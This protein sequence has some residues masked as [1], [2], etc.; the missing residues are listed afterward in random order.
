MK[1]FILLSIAVILIFSLFGCTEEK[2][3]A[4]ESTEEEARV[5]MTM[6]IDGTEY[7]VKY[8]LYRALFL[9]N[10]SRVDGG[11]NS[12]WTSEKSDEYIEKINKIIT[13]RTSEIFSVIHLATEIGF[14][15]YSEEVN[16]KI[17]TYV[18]GAVEGDGNQSGHGSYEKYLESLKNNNL[19]YSVATLMAR[20]AL[21]EEAIDKY[22]LG[23]Y[24]STLEVQKDGEFAYTKK[25]VKNYY[26]SSEC[27]RVLQS[28]FS[29]GIK[30]VEQMQ[31][32]R[33]TLLEKNSE[34]A[35]AAFIIGS[36]SATESDLIIDGK[37]SG[38]MIGKNEIIGS[39]YSPYIDEIF[40]LE[41]GN[42]SPVISLDNTN[43]DGF[44]VVYALEKT[45]EHFE[46]CYSSIR[47]S[48]LDNVVGTV[49]NNMGKALSSSLS[50]TDSY[51]NINHSSIKMN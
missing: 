8:E 48:Y 43:A 39:E 40:A 24:D 11:D 47:N 45:D 38:I 46:S 36:T 19:N 22:Y 3:P 2:Y 13:E 44:Y 35:L 31:T 4:V 37:I 6:S 27:Q 17:K 28:Y 16:K 15:P 10:K 9:N 49:L 23:E 51:N 26:N 20:Y 30:T 25:D 34:L 42:F 18:A 1:R 21:A 50:F 41:A 29:E 12:V 14:D 5:V 32:Y 7:E 33:N